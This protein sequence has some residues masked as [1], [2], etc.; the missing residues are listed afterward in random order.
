MQWSAFNTIKQSRT[1]CSM[2]WYR[3]G[4]YGRFQLGVVNYGIIALNIIR[5]AWCTEPPGDCHTPNWLDETSAGMPDNMTCK[6]KTWCDDLIIWYQDHPGSKQKVLRHVPDQWCLERHLNSMDHS[7]LS[8]ANSQTHTIA[9]GKI[10]RPVVMQLHLEIQ[11]FV[12]HHP[13]MKLKG[14]PGPYFDHQSQVKPKPFHS[15]TRM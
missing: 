10:G 1:L 8:F 6:E 15:L 3:F 5:V 7:S 11:T 14:Q 2:V 9:I 4:L 12:C 13:W